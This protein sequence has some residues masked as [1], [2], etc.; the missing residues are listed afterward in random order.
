M[1]TQTELLSVMPAEAEIGEAVGCSAWLGVIFGVSLPEKILR[2]AIFDAANPG[3][4]VKPAA[5]IVKAE[6]RQ[7]RLNASNQTIPADALPG[8]ALNPKPTLLQMLILAAH[9]RRLV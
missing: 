6:T 7:R 8:L 1:T 2:L 4:S 9:S 3:G 5:R